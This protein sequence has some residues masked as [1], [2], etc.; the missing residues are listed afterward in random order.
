MK[1]ERIT[2]G[3]PRTCFKIFL[4]SKL[5]K[6]GGKGRKQ[7]MGMAAES[8]PAGR[9]HREYLGCRGGRRSRAGSRSVRTRGDRARC[10]AHIGDTAGCSGARKTQGGKLKTEQNQAVTGFSTFSHH[11]KLKKSLSVLISNHYFLI[12]QP[13]FC[14][15]WNDEACWIVPCLIKCR[16][17]VKVL[18]CSNIPTFLPQILGYLIPQWSSQQPLSPRTLIW[19]SLTWTVW[20][21]R[22]LRYLRPHSLL[23][24]W[25]ITHTPKILG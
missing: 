19:V 6:Q 16:L 2:R 15:G 21:N 11:W 4:G 22:S 1:Q 24:I 17:W 12:Y 7:G 5:L 9:W 25:L 10:C 18:L 8:Q 23:Q 20:Q 3:W 14:D 13:Q